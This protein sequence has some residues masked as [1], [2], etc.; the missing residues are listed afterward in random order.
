[1][2]LFKTGE[3]AKFLGVSAKTIKRWRKSGKLTPIKSGDNGYCLYADFQ[4]GT[5]KNELGTKAGTTENVPTLQTRDNVNQLGK[6]TRENVNQPVKQTRENV[7]GAKIEMEEF[8]MKDKKNSAEHIAETIKN[9]VNFTIKSSNLQNLPREIIKLKRFLNVREDGKTPSGEGWQQSK[10][11][12]FLSEI[13]TDTAAFFIGTDKSDNGDKFCVLDFDHVLNDDGVFTNSDAQDFYN[14][15]RAKFP[16]AYCEKSISGHGLHAL[17]LPT[18]ETFTNF[19]ET[20]K[21]ANN[22]CV[23]V[24]YNFGKTITLTGNLYDCVANAPIPAGVSVDDFLRHLKAE[25]DT[26][27]ALNK[28]TQSAR[29]NQDLKT[30]SDDY[31]QARA[32]AML[33]FIPCSSQTY[34]DWLNVGMILHNNG[35][36]LADWINWSATDFDR[37]KEGECA[38]KWQGF[39]YNGGLTIATLH[40]FAKWYGYSEKDFRRQWYKDHPEFQ[41]NSWTD[42]DF[43]SE[44]ENNENE[45]SATKPTL[46]EHIRKRLFGWARSDLFNSRRILMFH[47]KN[48]RYLTDSGRW[49][50]YINNVWTDGGK[51]NGAILPFALN[52]ADLIF[53]NATN[54]E[55]Q[56]LCTQ[57]QQ[58]KTI[59]N[60][61]ELL[62]GESKIRITEKDLNTHKHL[63]NCKNGVVDL[64]TGD[65]LPHDSELLLTQCVNAE[66][67]KGY[68]NEVVDKFLQDILPDEDTR[69]ALLRY[70]GYCLTGENSAE[71]ALFIHGSGGNGKGTLSKILLELFADYACSFPIEAILTQPYNRAD[72]DSATPAFNKLQWRRL[73]LAEEIPAGRKLDYAKFKILTGGDN[74]PIRKL[75]QEATEI[76]DPVHKLI[77]SGNHLPELDDAHDPGILRRWIQIHFEQDFIGDKC[78]ETLKRRLLTSEVLS[79]LLNLLVE[80]SIEWY[81]HGLIVSDKMKNDRD[82]YFAENDFIAEFINEFCERGN[83]FKVKRLDLL[84]FLKNK[85]PN[86]TRGKSDPSLTNAVKRIE[87]IDYKQATGNRYYFLG[88]RLRNEQDLDNDCYLPTEE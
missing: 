58:R 50:T 62:K 48:F 82:S 77:F 83:G 23:E 33:D 68:H 37:F 85:Y 74:L 80:N 59:S 20:L 4:L 36:S 28:Q 21:F 69:N 10:N 75:H 54:K 30:D 1:M 7:T 31:D 2:K 19:K 87:G 26:K 84:K 65:L 12:K 47:N 86:E 72:G 34:E 79:A 64:Q 29:Q 18:D 81:K 5:I 17:L 38:K 39:K 46:D 44:N 73:A 56:K 32:R 42:F 24:F 43:S 49:Y 61:V 70:L 15:F 41:N 63:L 27:N 66:Y 14:N 3:A 60:A 40:K 13:N 55:E 11:Q 45:D 78:D 35:N 9:E 52:V 51:D 6:Q 57:W 22:S 8:F 76:K 25:I 71:K 53:R 88:V 67:H 16:T